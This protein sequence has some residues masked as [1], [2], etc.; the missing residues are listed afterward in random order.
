MKRLVKNRPFSTITHTQPV[1]FKA[2]ANAREYTGWML[3]TEGGGGQAWREVN[4]ATSDIKP[5]EI[6]Q[7]TFKY[8]TSVEQYRTTRLL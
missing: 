8:T 6:N 4:P 7:N 2:P 5:K 1:V 3:K